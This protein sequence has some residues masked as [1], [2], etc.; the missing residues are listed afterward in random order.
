MSE[1]QECASV[2]GEDPVLHISVREDGVVVGKVPWSIRY[3]LTALYI[4]F[5][6]DFLCAS[7]ALPSCLAGLMAMMTIPANIAII[8]TTNSISNRVKALV[9][10]GLRGVED[11][12]RGGFPCLRTLLNR[13]IL[14]RWY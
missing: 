2:L 12:E 3:W 13:D 7:L 1:P 6:S 8:A 4:V 14:Y 9:Y 10:E 5:R 11:E